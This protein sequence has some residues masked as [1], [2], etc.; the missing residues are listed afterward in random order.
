MFPPFPAWDAPAAVW[1]DG[2]PDGE[3]RDPLRALPGRV[4]HVLLANVRHCQPREGDVPIFAASESP[5][6]N[7]FPVRGHCARWGLVVCV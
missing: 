1:M 2:R 7:P 6:A 5:L 3:S 4:G